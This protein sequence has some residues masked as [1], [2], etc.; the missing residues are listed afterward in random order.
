MVLTQRPT[1]RIKVMHI[2]DLV[3]Q[4]PQFMSAFSGYSNI[5]ATR[6]NNYNYEAVVH[7]N[8]ITSL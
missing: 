6:S 1:P 2:Q 8:F 4:E 7:F 5:I 3:P